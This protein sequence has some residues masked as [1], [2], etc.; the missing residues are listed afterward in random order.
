MAMVECILHVK[1]S[2]GTLSLWKAL[3]HFVYIGPCL[4]SDLRR[5]EMYVEY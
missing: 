4:V 1:G 2:G 5:P 3:C